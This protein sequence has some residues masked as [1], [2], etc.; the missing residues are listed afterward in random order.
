MGTGEGERE[1]ASGEW[2][3]ARAS[4]NRRAQRRVG[5]GEGERERRVGAASG[6]TMP[7]ESPFK[8]ALS[9]TTF[10]TCYGQPWEPASGEWER[11]AASAK[12]FAFF[13]GDLGRIFRP[14]PGQ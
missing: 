1:P 3:P 7:S 6:E 12:R 4:G 9:A 11:R 5:T 8:M 14:P 2:E 10:L 13:G